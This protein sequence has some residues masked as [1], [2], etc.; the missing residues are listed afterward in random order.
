MVTFCW[1]HSLA[2]QKWLNQST[3]HL[4]SDSRRPK[5]PNIRWVWDPYQEEA[6]LGVV[7]PIEKHWQS[8]LWWVHSILN[9][10]KCSQLVD[11]TLYCPRENLPF[12]HSSFCHNS[13]T[14]CYYCS[15]RSLI[16]KS[17]DVRDGSEI[18]WKIWEN[19][20]KYVGCIKLH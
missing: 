7:R 10:S 2:L 12:G 8:L 1:L 9:S 13:L 11:V 6:I 3:C 14:S 18:W 19:S 20:G 17:L 16:W 15:R 5:E 4:K